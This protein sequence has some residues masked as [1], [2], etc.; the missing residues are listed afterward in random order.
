MPVYVFMDEVEYDTSAPTSNAQTFRRLQVLGNQISEH[1][2][3]FVVY[4]FDHHGTPVKLGNVSSP[5]EE[6]A[7]SKFIEEDVMG[8]MPPLNPEGPETQGGDE[9][10]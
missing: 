6:L 8:A 2:G 4:G 9:G 1:L 3:C 10:F 7:I 5:M